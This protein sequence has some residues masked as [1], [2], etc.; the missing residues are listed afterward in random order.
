MRFFERFANFWK[1]VEI[2][3]TP[4]ADTVESPPET[5]SQSQADEFQDAIAELK[6]AMRKL[7]RN[8]LRTNTVLQSDRNEIKQILQ[9]IIVSSGEPH[10]EM[11]LELLLVV[12]GL[13][14]G[15]HAIK[16]L[17]DE[18]RLVFAL[19]EGF[20]I[21]HERLLSVLKK[22]DVTPIESVGQPFVPHLHQA[23]DTVYAAEVPENAI[24]EE[25]RRG[26]LRGNEVLR[27]AEVVVARKKEK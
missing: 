4:P 5:V 19:A 2:T 3:H 14:E 21:V 6:D 8:Q 26:Y 9:Q 15:I 23:V 10:K 18:N 13:E 22:W 25:Q 11:L 16:Q 27:Y 7:G 1:Y 12:D 17:N 24:V 20:L